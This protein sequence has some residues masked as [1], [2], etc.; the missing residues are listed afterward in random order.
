MLRSRRPTAMKLRSLIGIL[1]LPGV[2]GPK[3]EGLAQNPGDAWTESALWGA[4]SSTPVATIGAL[5]GSDCEIFGSIRD[6]VLDRDGR[7]IVLDGISQR[8][9][10]FDAN[11]RCL[12]TLGREGEGPGE[13]R[14]ARRLELAGEDLLVLDPANGRMERF[15]LGSRSAERMPSVPL[16]LSAMD[17]C[18][19]DR[20][21][22]AAAHEGAAIHDIAADGTVIE[23]FGRLYDGDDVAR[24]QIAA[25][26]RI[27]CDGAR[28]LLTLAGHQVAAIRQFAVS[29]EM[30]W[31]TAVPGFLEPELIMD[32]RRVRGFRPSA[33]GLHHVATLLPLSAD[34]AL[35]QIGTPT[36]VG[37]RELRSFALD[38]RLGVIRPLDSRALPRVFD[39]HGDLVLAETEAAFP[40]LAVYRR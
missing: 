23:S 5:E 1:L 6:A 38:L 2:L 40:Q 17:F 25:P 29:G 12:Y 20:L 9:G 10:V 32:G 22:V 11:G 3:A 4:V 13:F 27:H 37:F 30:R 26:G 7:A 16:T 28:G 34:Q 8:V 19:G 14:D 24:S 31:E 36:D 18:F 35:V 15:R 39:I 21:Y 33:D